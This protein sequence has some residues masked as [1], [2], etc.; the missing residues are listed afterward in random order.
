MSG[1]AQIQG[2]G[3]A[4]ASASV[5]LANQTHQSASLE[6]CFFGLLRDASIPRRLIDAAAEGF[7]VQLLRNCLPV[8]G[9]AALPLAPPPASL[10]PATD[11]RPKSRAYNHGPTITVLPAD[12]QMDLAAPLNAK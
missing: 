11:P 5:P 3:S 6:Q 4:A 8:V 9:V 1:L 7:S 12:R 10:P 2:A